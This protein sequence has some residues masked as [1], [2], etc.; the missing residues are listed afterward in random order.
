MGAVAGTG[1]A[2]GLAFRSLTR[3]IFDTDLP[4]EQLEVDD[5]RAGLR[6]LHV[7]GRWYFLTWTPAVTSLLYVPG[8]VPV[9]VAKSMVSTTVVI[10]GMCLLRV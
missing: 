7:G 6:L 8:S 3:Y 5:G 4:L 10:F 2:R 9:L 1:R